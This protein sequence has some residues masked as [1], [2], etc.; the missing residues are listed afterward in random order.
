[1]Q[2]ISAA[3]TEQLA[4]SQLLPWY[5][6]KLVACSAL[7]CAQ[8]D[9]ECEFMRASVLNPTFVKELMFE[10]ILIVLT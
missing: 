1:M 5:A 9:I 3:M 8:L 7:Q 10:T 2:F 6:E 4:N